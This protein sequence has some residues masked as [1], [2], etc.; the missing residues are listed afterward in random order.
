MRRWWIELH[1]GRFECRFCG[2]VEGARHRGWC[3]IYLWFHTK[4]WFT[5]PRTVCYLCERKHWLFPAQ[6]DLNRYWCWT[7]GR[8]VTG[9]EQARREHRLQRGA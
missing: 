1:G 7:W 5:V 3:P 9:A 8:W 4:W 6:T 2:T